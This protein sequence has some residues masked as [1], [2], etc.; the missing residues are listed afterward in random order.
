MIK[1]PGAVP[2]LYHVP[3]TQPGKL[4]LLAVWPRAAVVQQELPEASTLVQAG[5][6]SSALR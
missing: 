2:Q 4:S 1:P 5:A 3:G 6:L